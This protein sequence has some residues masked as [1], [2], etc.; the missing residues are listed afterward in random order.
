MGISSDLGGSPCREGSISC[1]LC[2]APRRG[3]YFFR[4]EE[5]RLR[6]NAC[7]W[8]INSQRLQKFP[9]PSIVV[10]Q[11]LS[12]VW[13]FTTPWTATDQAS[14]SFTISQGL[15]R[16]MSIELMMPSNHLILCCPVFL[17]PSIFRSIRIFS[18][19]PGSS[20]QVAKVLELQHQSFWWIFR[21][22]FL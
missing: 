8:R 6:E 2:K 5:A 12:H 13:C 3:H 17:L 14:L 1:L 4:V 9:S 21:V 16:L 18:S 11:S 15:L 20:H 22:Y 10:V 7:C 19:D